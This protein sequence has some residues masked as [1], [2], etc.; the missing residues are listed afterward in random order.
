MNMTGSPVSSYTIIGVSLQSSTSISRSSTLLLAGQMITPTEGALVNANLLFDSQVPLLGLNLFE[1]EHRTSATI[2]DL[3]C[4]SA[5]HLINFFIR[6]PIW[7]KADRSCS[8]PTIQASHFFKWRRLDI[9]PGVCQT[10]SVTCLLPFQRS[11]RPSRYPSNP[12]PILAADTPSLP[13]A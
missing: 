1:R 7:Q 10:V 12:Q 6:S 13:P 5:L 8:R 4:F 2:L 9:A 11:P 3:A